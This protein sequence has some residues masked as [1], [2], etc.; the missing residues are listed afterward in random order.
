M[1]PASARF[2]ITIA[3]LLTAGHRAFG[4]SWSSTV[5]RRDRF[6]AWPTVAW[7]D[8]LGEPNPVAG[9]RLPADGNN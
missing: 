7:V 2:W 5:F 6:G 8:A 4:G 3:A 9:R 1:L